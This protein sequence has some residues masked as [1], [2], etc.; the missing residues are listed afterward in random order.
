M[1]G[2]G[3]RDS[4][5]FHSL[6]SLSE[7][8]EMENIIN[9]MG[10]KA[11]HQEFCDELAT[12][13]S[14]SAIRA[15][16]AAL[17]WQQVQ[18]WFQ[19]KHKELQAETVSSPVALKL[20]VDLSDANISRN[21]SESSQKPEGNDA[22]DLSE[23][24]FEAKSFKDDAWYDVASFLTFRVLCTGEL[25]ARV[26]FA[27]FG[28]EEDEWVNVRK[29]IR[30]RSIPLE[31]SECH[32]INTGDLVLCF[33]DRLNQ[34]VYCDAHIMEIQRKPHDASSCTC[35]FIVRYDHDFS[36]EMVELSRLCCRPRQEESPQLSEEN[37]YETALS[38]SARS[39]WE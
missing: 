16:R 2:V 13:L 29:G 3:S 38:I 24:A 22:T 14:S 1:E 7:I 12:R 9:E 15:G 20:F 25:E 28:K 37:Q 31:P 17:T 30:E 39:L 27:G 32:R 21:A 36:Q 18:S 5:S 34:A 4:R 10:E 11:L 33:Q 26:R 35:D 6:F 23:L 19:D 8:V